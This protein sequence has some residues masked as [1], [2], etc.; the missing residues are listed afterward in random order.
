MISEPVITWPLEQKVYLRNNQSGCRAGMSAIDAVSLT[1]YYSASYTSRGL[2]F[3]AIFLDI[4]KAYDRVHT[5]IL[6]KKQRDLHAFFPRI[7][8]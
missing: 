3:A 7:Q 2:N 8:A 6:L 4:G 5:G 1:Q